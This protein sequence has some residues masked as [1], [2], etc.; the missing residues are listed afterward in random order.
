MALT[1]IGDEIYEFTRQA[2]FICPVSG[3]GRFHRQD[4]LRKSAGDPYPA[5]IYLC[6]YIP[7]SKHSMYSCLCPMSSL[8]ALIRWGNSQIWIISQRGEADCS[9]PY[10]L[11]PHLL[12][13]P[14]ERFGVKDV[15]D[16]TGRIILILFPVR[17]CGRCTSVC[18]AS[19]TW[20]KL[21]PRKIIMDVR[22]RMKEKGPDWC[23]SGGIFG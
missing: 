3:N 6:Q 16:V 20:K 4:H 10:P 2:I 22:A 11:L 9:I 8:L 5:D 17:Q 13:C 21:S 7:Y 12:R 14:S 18:P 23:G 15:E 1:C 19:L